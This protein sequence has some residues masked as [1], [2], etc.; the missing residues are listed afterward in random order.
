ML[1]FIQVLAGYRSLRLVDGW[2]TS[3]LYVWFRVQ[4]L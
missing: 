3:S 1:H 4:V 2:H